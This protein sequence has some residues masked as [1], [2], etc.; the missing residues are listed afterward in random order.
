M[1]TLG[2][3]LPEVASVWKT[4]VMFAVSGL[5][6]HPPQATVGILWGSTGTGTAR[7]AGGGA[8]DVPEDLSGCALIADAQQLLRHHGQALQAR[9]P[10][11]LQGLVHNRFERVLRQHNVPADAGTVV[12]R[13]PDLHPQHRS[14]RANTY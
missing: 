3:P 9:V 14:H 10:Q 6:I 2:G 1:L 13:R 12:H 8:A 11:L 5:D 4:N 7:R